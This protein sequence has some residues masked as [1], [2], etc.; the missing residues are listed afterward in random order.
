MQIP[1]LIPALL[2]ILGQRAPTPPDKTPPGQQ[3]F[4]RVLAQDTPA[5]EAS[6]TAAEPVLYRQDATPAPD[7]SGQTTWP[8]YVPLPWRSELFPRASFFIKF[9]ERD[10]E[11]KDSVPASSLGLFIQLQADQ[12]G[13]LWLYWLVEN[14]RCLLQIYTPDI[15]VARLLRDRLSEL[16]ALLHH[17]Y[18]ESQVICHYRPDVHTA[19]QLLPE[20]QNLPRAILIDLTV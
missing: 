19:R 5:A 8:G 13:H 14:Q 9:N 6:R 2:R 4:A 12:L 3:D 20:L 1:Q 15:E 10:A 18:A 7:T 16:E 11:A 17:S